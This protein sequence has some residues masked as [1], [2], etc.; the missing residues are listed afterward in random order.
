MSASEDP[1][2]VRSRA[3]ILAA[4]VALLQDEGY[5]GFSVEGV[6]ARSGVAKST[7]YRHWPERQVLLLDAFRSVKFPPEHAPRFAP[8][9]DLYADLVREM[10]GLAA[11]L[12]SSDWVEVL[13]AIIEAAEREPEFLALARV[14]VEERRA[15]VRQR[16]ELAVREGDL[17]GDSD[18]DLLLSQL[19]GPLFYRRLIAHQPVD[20]HAMIDRLVRQ[21]LIGAGARAALLDPCRSVR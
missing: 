11:G 10:R 9:A 21:V 15:P 8:T 7:I 4:A 17:P 16:V 6:S 5:R 12:T 3:T 20:D 2:I 14:F 1:R 18:V 13:P 19:G